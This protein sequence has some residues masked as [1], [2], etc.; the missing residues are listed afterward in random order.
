MVLIQESVSTKT[1][2]TPVSV[3]PLKLL[4]SFDSVNSISCGTAKR[5]RKLFPFDKSDV[6]L[7]TSLLVLRGRNTRLDSLNDQNPAFVILVY[8][9]ARVLA[10]YKSY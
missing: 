1:F 3:L 5:K 6:K 8:N 2:S 7:A 4:P 9:I 10:L